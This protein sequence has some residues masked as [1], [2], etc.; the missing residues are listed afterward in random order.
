MYVD[1]NKNS[2][3]FGGAGQASYI[4]ALGSDVSSENIMLSPD[5]ESNLKDVDCSFI[6]GGAKRPT[7]STTITK[8]SL[9][10]ETYFGS[11]IIGGSLNKIEDSNRSIIVGGGDSTNGFFASFFGINVLTG[12]TSSSIISSTNCKLEKGFGSAIVSAYDSNITGDTATP[13]SYASG[14][15]VIAGGSNNNISLKNNSLGLA[16]GN[17]M[18]AGYLNEIVG[19]KFCS[20]I[21]GR[22]NLIDEKDVTILSTHVASCAIVGGSD[23]TIILP[24]SKIQQ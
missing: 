15:S 11:G 16:Q 7:A 17:S 21:G 5:S 3:I 10:V 22:D 13:G 2:G 23:N 14:G 8:V 1:N 19:S 18:I 4:D 12:S 9:G 24:L 6:V 20:I